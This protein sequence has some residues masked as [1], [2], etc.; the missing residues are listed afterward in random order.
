ME[1]EKQ[2][3]KELESLKKG[4]RKED[5][6]E[7]MQMKDNLTVL[8]EM[9]KKA[10]DEMAYDIWKSLNKGEEEDEEVLRKRYNEA[11][12][13]IVMG[14]MADPDVISFGSSPKN[15]PLQ[16][17]PIVD[18]ARSRMVGEIVADI[19]AIASDEDI[20]AISSDVEGN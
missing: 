7:L 17:G 11:L 20:P 1:I 13:A 18:E 10:K 6:R 8:E 16:L 4:M 15:E 2:Y 9:N 3:R 19:P 5:R 14:L 12:F